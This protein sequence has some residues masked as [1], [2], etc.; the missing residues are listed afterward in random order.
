MS[1]LELARCSLNQATINNAD[2]QTAIDVAT[3]I[4]IPAIG[5]WR[6]QVAE[7]GVSSASRAIRDA[8]L[9]VTSLC[10]GGFF[11]SADPAAWQDE[12]DDNRRAIDEAH[13]IGTRVLV[14][15]AGGIP[16]GGSLTDAHARVREAI[17][18]LAP[19]AKAAGVTLAL[20]PMHPVFAADRG[21]VSTIAHALDIVRSLP[22]DVAGL[23]VDS[24]HVWWDWTLEQQIRDAAQA[25]RLTL[26]QVADW[27]PPGGRDPLV[28]R[29]F[30]GDGS[31]DFA[32]FIALVES[33]GYTGDIE[34]EIF[35][36]DL[37]ARDPRL[38]GEQVAEAHRR[39]IAPHLAPADT[40][41]EPV[42]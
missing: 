9:R 28:A 17:E 26:V 16:A 5:V 7:M 14:L 1:A 15:V 11:T 19:D 12:L 29:A 13:Q 41:G 25:D 36:T 21:V 22:S 31:I 2:L 30:P 35:N 3:G 4:G 38:V 10:R 6:K 42:Q 24:Y 8:G 37:W 34:W 23:A 18:T 32:S 40:K 39:L 33:V 20:E 27:A